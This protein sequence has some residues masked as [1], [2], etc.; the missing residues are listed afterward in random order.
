MDKNPPTHDLKQ[1]PLHLAVKFSRKNI[2][3]LIFNYVKDKNPKDRHGKTP[4]HIAVEMGNEDIYDII[5]ARTKELNQNDFEGILHLAARKRFD[6][7]G[8]NDYTDCK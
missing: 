8:Q 7:N 5:M 2:F 1:T 4:L 6:F 3:K